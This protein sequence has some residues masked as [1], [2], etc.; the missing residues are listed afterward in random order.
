MHHEMALMC[1]DIE[2]TV[3]ELTERGARFT[4]GV[5]DQGFGVTATIDV[6]GAGEMMIYQPRH[7]VAHSL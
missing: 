4:H 7:P 2:A 6:P 3:A 1:E 5:C